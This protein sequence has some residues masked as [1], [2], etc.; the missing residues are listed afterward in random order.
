MHHIQYI[1][2]QNKDQRMKLVQKRLTE[3]VLM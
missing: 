1:L 2:K 3:T